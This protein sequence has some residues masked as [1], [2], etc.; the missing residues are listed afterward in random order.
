[1]KQIIFIP[2]L[3]AAAALSLLA[4]ASSCAKVSI[5]KPNQAEQHIDFS[6]SVVTKAPVESS[7]DMNEF[8]VWAAYYVDGTLDYKPMEGIRVY[9]RRLSIRI[10]QY[11]RSR[12]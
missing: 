1:M 3:N 9:R 7:A 5:D 8:A 10:R 6:T 11:W 4:F 12:R 2:V